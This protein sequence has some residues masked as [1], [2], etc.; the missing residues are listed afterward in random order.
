MYFFCK[1]TFLLTSPER[2]FHR[3]DVPRGAQIND[4]IYVGPD[5]PSLPHSWVSSLSG[6]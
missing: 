2:Y 3:C 1:Y 5:L 4:L 6:R